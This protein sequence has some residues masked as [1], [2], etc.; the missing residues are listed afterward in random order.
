MQIY[1]LE[2]FTISVFPESLCTQPRVAKGNPGKEGRRHNKIVEFRGQC[3]DG[4]DI[5]WKY[6]SNIL[7]PVELGS[8]HGPWDGRAKAG[9]VNCFLATQPGLA[10]S[11]NFNCAKTGMGGIRQKLGASRRE[12]WLTQLFELRDAVH[13]LL[14]GTPRPSKFQVCGSFCC[15]GGSN[16]LAILQYLNPLHLDHTGVEHA[17]LQSHL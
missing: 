10:W 9:G 12:G 4:N 5:L 1:P 15:V 6:F 13:I 3:G 2:T 17:S 14:R 7:P 8:I 16:F 11:C